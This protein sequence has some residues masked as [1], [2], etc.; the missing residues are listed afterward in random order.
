MFESIGVLN[1]A[2]TLDGDSI[3]PKNLLAK[4]LKP[5]PLGIIVNGL[6]GILH[7][8]ANLT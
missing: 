5:I 7:T 6:K 4:G 1:I 2:K 3:V 8:S